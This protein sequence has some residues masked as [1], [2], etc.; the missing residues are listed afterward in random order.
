M[1]LI[2]NLSEGFKERQRIHEKTD[3]IFYFILDDKGNKFLQIDTFG[4][5][6]RAIPGKVSQSIQFSPTAIQQLKIIL[7]SFD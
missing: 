1:A 7:K 6:E 4:S 5:N 3:S 2:E